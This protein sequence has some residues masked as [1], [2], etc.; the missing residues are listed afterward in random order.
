RKEIELEHRPAVKG[1]DADGRLRG[2]KQNLIATVA[3]IIQP[4]DARAA[5]ARLA[6]NFFRGDEMLI[7]GGTQMAEIQP[8]K[9]TVPVS[10]VA[11]CLPQMVFRLFDVGL[12]TFDF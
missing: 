12:A 1:R 6:Q 11:L 2:R 4:L 9:Q 5:G 7:E 3:I 10:A 8:A